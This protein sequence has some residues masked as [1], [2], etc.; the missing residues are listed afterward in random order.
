MQQTV[1]NFASLYLSY[2]SLNAM[3]FF[4]VNQKHWL[5]LNIVYFWSTLA[6]FDKI[7]HTD[8]AL[9]IVCVY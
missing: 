5:L 1:L 6:E 9:S 2:S 3:D 8:L 7:L 4:P